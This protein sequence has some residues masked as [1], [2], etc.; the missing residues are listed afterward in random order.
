MLPAEALAKLDAMDE[1]DRLLA[2]GRI[3]SDYRMSAAEV[4]AQFNAWKRGDNVA[5]STFTKTDSG[6]IAQSGQSANYIQDASKF[7]AKYDPSREGRARQSQIE[8]AVICPECN[9]ALGIPS[10]RP[11]KVTCPSCMTEITFTA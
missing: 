4:E 3:G 2:F 1:Y 8:Q 11:I 6:P 10:V 7:R 9:A 5:P